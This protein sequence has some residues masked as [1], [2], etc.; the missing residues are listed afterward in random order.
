LRPIRF[1]RIVTA[2]VALLLGVFWTL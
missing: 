1:I 2:T